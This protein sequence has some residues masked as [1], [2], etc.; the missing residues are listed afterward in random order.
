MYI[1]MGL[2]EVI[3]WF[4]W[5]PHWHR[6]WREVALYGQES[7]VWAGVSPEFESWL[8]QSTAEVSE[9]AKTQ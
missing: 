7:Q 4:T 5:V 1:C 8:H 3:G 2:R 6:A 9:R